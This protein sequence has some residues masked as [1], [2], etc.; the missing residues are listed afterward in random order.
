MSAVAI[1]GCAGSRAIIRH[2]PPIDR[3]CDS[4]GCRPHRPHRAVEPVRASPKEAKVGSAKRIVAVEAYAEEPRSRFP[5]DAVLAGLADEPA[6][7]PAGGYRDELR[8]PV[9]VPQ[10][11]IDGKRYERE[12]VVLY[13]PPPIIDIDGIRSALRGSF[14]D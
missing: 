12:P 7:M 1:T 4:D 2:S 10:T 9:F 13:R 11:L 14:D 5:S 3:I 6:A 8:G